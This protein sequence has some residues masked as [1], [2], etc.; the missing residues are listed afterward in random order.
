MST[1]VLLLF[2]VAATAAI[3]TPDSRLP[4]EKESITKFGLS[5]RFGDMDAETFMNMT[6][7]QYKKM[8]GKRMKLKE[9]IALKFMKKKLKKQM[10][11]RKGQADSTNVLLAILLAFFIGGLG[12]HR[13]VMGSEPIIILWYF[14]LSLIVVGLILA[15]IDFIRLIINPDPYVDNNRIFA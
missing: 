7:K 9:R 13:V 4:L 14:L 5:E 1:L 10:K 11:K 12:L 3:L 8:T 2:T 6:P 15:F